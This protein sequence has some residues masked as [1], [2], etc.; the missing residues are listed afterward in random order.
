MAI[1]LL[2]SVRFHEK[3]KSIDRMV[4][5]ISELEGTIACRYCSQCYMY[6]VYSFILQSVLS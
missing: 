2:L 6:Y 5:I 3:Q 4:S 1:A